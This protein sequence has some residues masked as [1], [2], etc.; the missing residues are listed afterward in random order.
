MIFPSFLGRRFCGGF[1]IGSDL[2]SGLCGSSVIAIEGNGFGRR[3]M[4]WQIT[5]ATKAGAGAK[6]EFAAEAQKEMG[7]LPDWLNDRQ[8]RPQSVNTWCVTER[9]TGST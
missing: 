1:L 2:I 5:G 8:K 6:G 3:Q 4:C 7:T 9:Q